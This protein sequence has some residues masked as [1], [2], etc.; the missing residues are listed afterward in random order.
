MYFYREYGGQEIDL[1]LEDYKKRYQALEIKV[2]EKGGNKD[3]FP[4]PHSFTTVN[5]QNYF[6]KIKSALK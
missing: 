1:V 5:T 4:L 6:E 2:N 3:I